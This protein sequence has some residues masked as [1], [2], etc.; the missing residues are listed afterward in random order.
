VCVQ[1]GWLT[2]I[3][4]NRR[5][6]RCSRDYATYLNELVLPDPA[7]DQFT[8]TGRHPLLSLD[9]RYRAQHGIASIAR[10][11]FHGFIARLPLFVRSAASFALQNRN[12]VNAFASGMARYRGD[13]RR[14]PA[15]VDALNLG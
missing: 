4:V 15:R 7:A 11:L 12:L 1:V 10:A 2:A 5:R 13:Q 14:W 8:A 9:S 6:R 3:E